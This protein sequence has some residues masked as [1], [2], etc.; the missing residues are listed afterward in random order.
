VATT[1]L[2]PKPALTIVGAWQEGGA[3]YGTAIG[4]ENIVNDSYMVAI[5][6]G[7]DSSGYSA[8]ESVFIGSDFTTFAPFYSVAIGHYLGVYGPFNVAIGNESKAVYK[9]VSIGN[10]AGFSH[11]SF[12][13]AGSRGV[14]IGAGAYIPVGPAV[15]LGYHCLGVYQGTALGNNHAGGESVAVGTPIVVLGTR[16]VA[17]GNFISAYD[18]SVALG[19][20][21]ATYGSYSVILGHTAS[22]PAIGCFVNTGIATSTPL[23]PVVFH[24]KL[25]GSTIC[26]KQAT[27][28]WGNGS[29][30]ATVSNGTPGAIG[31][32]FVF[33]L[34][35][36]IADSSLT[37]AFDSGS[38]TFSILLATNDPSTNTL[39]NIAALFP[40]NGFVF[41]YTAGFDATVVS[42]TF[43]ENF[44]NGTD[45]L[46]A[47]LPAP[48]RS[49]PRTS[50]LPWREWDEWK[51]W[52]GGRDEE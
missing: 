13:S 21:C 18:N 32:S 48:L 1:S 19:S 35:N 9:G 10:Y 39:A 41:S 14:A 26:P 8:R 17:I 50:P 24:Q 5:G 43:T 6:R 29:Y 37:T 42:F 3:S 15:A 23:R 36:N 47:M 11:V 38:S 51:N 16:A 31:N 12:E 28:A 30:T 44:A 22:D 46:P 33:T 4:S 49:A 34:A 52:R 25:V 27:A 2:L 20:F 40:S 7:I 45:G